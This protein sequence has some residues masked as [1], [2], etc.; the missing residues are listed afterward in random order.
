MLANCSP[1]EILFIEI[2]EHIGARKY[3]PQSS[4][5]GQLEGAAYIIMVSA[6]NMRSQLGMLFISIALSFIIENLI[7]SGVCY[8][9]YTEG[10]KKT[11]QLQVSGRLRQG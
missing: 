7:F 6:N 5:D 3:Y 1:L 2:R 4:S 11:H 10:Y 8:C 9:L